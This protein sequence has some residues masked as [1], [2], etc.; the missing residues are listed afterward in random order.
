MT[1]LKNLSVLLLT[2][3]SVVFAV[4]NSIVAIVNDTVITMDDINARINKN[5]TT[6]QKIAL[7]EQEIDL[8]L[9]KEKIQALEIKPKSE[10]IN[11]ALESIAA[12]NGLTL[13]QLRADNQFD[14][15]VKIVIQDFSLKGLK[16]LVLQQSNIT[17]TVAEIDNE[18]SNN[19]NK[20]DGAMTKAHLADI[21]AQLIY[22]K[23]NAFFQSWVKDLRKNAY[24]EIFKDKL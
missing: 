15:I 7:I 16:Q 20:I 17:V 3:S 2:L 12:Q 8:E 6:K 1:L 9:Q 10:I 5:A 24:I 11:I 23:Q 19:P 4:P 21:K 18:I 13:T 14:Q 22:N